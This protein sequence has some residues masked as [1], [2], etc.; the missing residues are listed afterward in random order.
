MSLFVLIGVNEKGW[1]G[2]G[3]GRLDLLGTGWTRGRRWWRSEEWAAAGAI[4]YGW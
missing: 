2:V 4:G 1:E 3:S